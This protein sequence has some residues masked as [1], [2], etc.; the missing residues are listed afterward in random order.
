MIIIPH[1]RHHIY[2]TNNTRSKFLTESAFRRKHSMELPSLKNKLNTEN[3]TFHVK[4]IVCKIY[5]HA[6]IIIK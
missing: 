6:I 4:T 3:V 5:L 2:R 1:F